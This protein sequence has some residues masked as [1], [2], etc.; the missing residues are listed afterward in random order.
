MRVLSITDSPT[1]KRGDPFLFQSIWIYISSLNVLPEI[2]SNALERE[3]LHRSPAS[4]TPNMDAPD[5]YHTT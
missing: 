3:Y 2:K 5:N 1:D 4:A